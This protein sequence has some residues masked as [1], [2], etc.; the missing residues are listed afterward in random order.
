MTASSQAERI[1]IRA[2]AVQTVGLRWVLAV[3]GLALLLV[4]SGY[5]AWRY[6]AM[7]HLG[8]YHD[9]AVYWITAQSLAAGHGYRIGHLAE[10]PAETKYPPLYPMLLSLVWRVAGQFP[11]NLSLVMA[12]Q[13]LFAPVYFALAWVYFRRVFQ[14]SGAA[15]RRSDDAEKPG[16]RHRLDDVGSRSQVLRVATMEPATRFFRARLSACATVLL[17]FGP[18]TTI[19]AV[20]PMTELPFSV[21]LLGVM[22]LI[23]GRED[24]SP[25]HAF[26]AGG[27]AAAG[28]LMRTNAIALAASVPFVLLL[29][30]RIKPAFAF[31]A[32]LGA[33]ILGWQGWCALNA[34][35]AK[36]D[37]LSYYTSYVGFYLRT[38]SW[39]E[40]PHRLWV[41][42]DAVIEW[43]ARLVLF[44]VG[45]EFWIRPVAW[46]M[47]AAAAA[48][49]V[50]LYRRGFR[51][52]PVFAALFIVVLLF[53]KYPP[54]Q[55][56]VYPLLPLYI[57]G[58]ATKLHEIAALAVVTWRTKPAADR[59]AAVVML[60]LIAALA[61]GSLFLMLRGTVSL[62]PD[63]F[64]ECETRMAQM[65]P[66]Y[67]WIASH[68]APGDRFAAYD[69]TLL[70]LY[71][72]RHGYT[73]PVLP[74][75]VYEQNPEAVSAYVLGLPELWRARQ[76]SYVLVTA[77]DFRR[78]LHTPAQDSLARL[79]QDRTHFQP[80]YADPTAQVYRFLPLP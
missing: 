51:Q 10:N 80:V 26:L 78:D 2:A 69:D 11:G 24:L 39:A 60:A 64:Q 71:A 40:L 12:V 45:N 52:Y 63:Y 33:A 18:M 48:G 79:V 42:L 7:P 5:F 65:Q 59:V 14:E 15:A 49:V 13:W 46:V 50:T 36:D 70:Y 30:R 3:L 37:V 28:F 9:D 68:T 22:L 16:S 56:F 8:S 74:R 55:R 72:G 43:Q 1:E 25:Q 6:R 23:E 29:R 19:F 66:V 27:I 31:F 44:H 57:A 53:W 62:L 34:Y 35:P 32:P 58:L 77:S 41:N 73:V 67:G 20:T 75:L 54:D 61:G 21:L 47:T 4:P 38:F 17:A 76:V